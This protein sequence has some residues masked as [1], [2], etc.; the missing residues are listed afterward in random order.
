MRRIISIGRITGMAA[1]VSMGATQAAQAQS[2]VTSFIPTTW[3]VGGFGFVAPKYEGSRE[4]RVIGF[5]MAFPAGSGEGWFQFKAPDDVRLRLINLQGLE[6]GPVAGYRFGREEDDSRR[7]RGLGDIDGGLVVGGFAAYRFGMARAFA[8]YNAAVTGDETGGLLK[9]G[10]EGTTTLPGRIGLTATVGATWA[11]DDY[12]RSFFGVSGV[13][14]ARSALAVYQP[15]SGIKDVF[16]SLS[17]DIPLDARW[18]LRAF[19]RYAQLVGDA[20]NSPIV[21]REG[22]LSGGLGLT[23]RFSFGQ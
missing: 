3:D 23:Y 7:L 5:P 1:A 13:Q 9:F 22:Q 11:S 19:G 10:L 4:H 16:T 12:M 2:N 14:S 6:L 15:S 8:S 18:T 17:A 20:A 21:E